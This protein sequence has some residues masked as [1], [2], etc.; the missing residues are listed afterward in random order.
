MIVLKNEIKMWKPSNRS[1]KLNM[2]KYTFIDNH[3]FQM[4]KYNKNTN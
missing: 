1:W 4:H 3:C 2:H